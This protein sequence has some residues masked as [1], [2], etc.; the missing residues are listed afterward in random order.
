MAQWV[1]ALGDLGLRP[2][3]FLDPFP[4]LSLPL[5]FCQSLLSY[6]NKSL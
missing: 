1:K 6:L 2:K 4:Y 5:V 3:V